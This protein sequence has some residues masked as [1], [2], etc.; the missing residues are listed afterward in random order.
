[1]W[2]LTSLPDTC[3]CLACLSGQCQLRIQCRL[4][5]L[6]FCVAYPV[7]VLP[8]RSIRP[9]W[10]QFL[11]S[12]NASRMHPTLCRLAGLPSLNLHNTAVSDA[13]A[14][15]AMPCIVFPADHGHVVCAY[16]MRRGCYGRCRRCRFTKVLRC[17]RRRHGRRSTRRLTT[18]LVQAVRSYHDYCSLLIMLPWQPVSCVVPWLK[19]L[20]N[21][22]LG[23]HLALLRHLHSLSG[24]RPCHKHTA[25]TQDGPPPNAPCRRVL[26]P[27]ETVFCRMLSRCL[28][29]SSICHI[30]ATCC[31][32]SIRLLLRAYS[33]PKSGGGTLTQVPFTACPISSVGQTRRPVPWCP[34]EPRVG[35][36]PLRPEP[37]ALESLSSTLPL[38]RM[39]GFDCS[40]KPGIL[41]IDA[42][43]R[44]RRPRTTTSTSCYSFTGF[45]PLLRPFMLL[46]LLETLPC[47]GASHATGA[48]RAYNRAVRRAAAHPQQGT[49]YRGRWH[50]LSNS[51]ARV[52]SPQ[53]PR[54][55]RRDLS[56]SSHHAPRLHVATY[57]AGGLPT[58][59]YHELLVKLREMP[60][61]T[62]PSVVHVQ[63]SHWK[64]DLEYQ[65]EGWL[66]I[67][68]ASP[69]P[70]AG[71]LITLVNTDH[72]SPDQVAFSAPIPGRL[73]HTR[74]Q[75]GET[76]VDSVNLYQ[77]VLH[78]SLSRQEQGQQL[79][80]AAQ[81]KAV[82]R[83]LHTLLLS[84][85]RRHLLVLAGDFN[86]PPPLVRGQ[87]GQRADK[88]RG[89]AV[90]D[91]HCLEHL[92]QDH[93]L[94]LLNSW[95]RSAAATF[96]SEQSR[97]LID[98]VYVRR[99]QADVV[100]RQSCP[101]DWSLATWRRGGKHWAVTATLP[102]LSCR[103]LQRAKST[104][105]LIDLECLRN[106]CRDP[107]H[108][109]VLRL[110]EAA[111]SWVRSNPYGSIAQLNTCLL[112]QVRVLFPAR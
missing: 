49:Y 19:W 17:R 108:P 53:S 88:F 61:S 92:I 48:K 46:H 51:Q 71:G 29:S 73:L 79:T 27:W 65:T 100:A 36:L 64:S 26:C 110:R 112:D 50:C 24:E 107:T 1:M 86:S 63:E 6:G 62:R 106:V 45:L 69:S 47:L 11:A 66:V 22:W 109:A 94:I 67:S 84:I 37:V 99:H 55:M 75:V 18:L 68:S 32:P 5:V 23:L 9:G 90:A 98:H 28:S 31:R 52:L 60:R 35:R 97:T 34:L 93:G 54:L 8:T 44:S 83:A 56:Q 58:D 33:G 21:C 42:A 77:K 38:T 43:L 57:N 103:T 72:Y 25:C 78:T 12:T 15:R 41:T 85:P 80:P 4:T 89:P 16:S 70:M 101:Q 40:G 104:R 13:W 14:V 2:P 96:R 91:L 76:A 102:F 74:I 82:W 95:T 59:A 81:R 87:V 7:G 111:S 10:Q 3:T 30:D 105:P 39:H 20:R